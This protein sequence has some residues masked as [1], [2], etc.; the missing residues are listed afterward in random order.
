MAMLGERLRP[1]AQAGPE[2]PS[3]GNEGDPLWVRYA[4]LMRRGFSPETST[5]VAAAP[6]APD[7]VTSLLLPDL[8]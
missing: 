6:V 7:K 3:P 5:I 1:I 2:Q 4:D 8:R